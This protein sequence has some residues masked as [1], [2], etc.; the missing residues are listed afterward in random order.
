M[1]TPRRSPRSGASDT[2]AKRFQELRTELAEIEYFCKGTVLTRRMKCGKP[3]CACHTQPSK[4]HGPY[5]EWTYKAQGKTVNVRLTKE[6]APLYQAAAKQYR[7]LKAT[8][9]RLEKISRKALAKS[10]KDA[11]RRPPN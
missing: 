2:Y 10:A 4:R 11:A 7:Q 3:Q 8:L 6:A 5:Y 9:N 1:P